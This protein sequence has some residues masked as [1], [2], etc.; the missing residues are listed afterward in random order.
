M[1][2]FERKD[3][4]ARMSEN[5]NERAGIKRYSFL[6][7]DNIDSDLKEEIEAKE[8]NNLIEAIN[9]VKDILKKM[10]GRKAEIVTDYSNLGCIQISD[11]IS[12]ES[13]KV[14]YSYLGQIRIGV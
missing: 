13:I 8:T 14:G 5:E 6:A 4:I 10:W 7:D 3:T 9:M 12:E 2:L 11:V 1:G